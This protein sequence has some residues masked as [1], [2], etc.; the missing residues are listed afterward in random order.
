MSSRR[1]ANS[2]PK[3]RAPLF[4]SSVLKPRTSKM[5]N[6][7]KKRDLIIVVWDACLSRL[8]SSAGIFQQTY[9]PGLK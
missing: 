2:H 1:T 8:P 7:M 4:A 6:W 9:T 3:S 5:S